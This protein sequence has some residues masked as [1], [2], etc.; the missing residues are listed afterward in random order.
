MCKFCLSQWPIFQE[1]FT[2]LFCLLRGFP[3]SSITEVTTR[4]NALL[5]HTVSI[6]SYGID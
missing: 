3:C 4:M 1:A 5:D 2:V 6:R